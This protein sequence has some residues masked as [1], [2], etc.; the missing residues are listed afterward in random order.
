M[1]VRV[2]LGDD[3][4]PRMNY[5][6]LL[7]GIALL[8]L[9]SPLP[10]IGWIINAFVLFLGLGA[11]MIGAQGQMRVYRDV[12]TAMPLRVSPP[13]LPRRAENSRPLPPPILDD[14]PRSVGME[15]LPEGFTW[16]D[17]WE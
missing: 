14:Q 4:G 10:V 2:A 3:S 6:S 11:V 7:I 17:D 16:W 9:L 5:L 8:A 15:N 13:L 12:G 1:L